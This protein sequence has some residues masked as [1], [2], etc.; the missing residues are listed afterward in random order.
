MEGKSERKAG[1]EFETGINGF[2]VRAGASELLLRLCLFRAQMPGE[3]ESRRLQR[4]WNVYV[5]FPFLFV[6]SSAVY[7]VVGVYLIGLCRG[8]RL[9]VLYVLVSG[10]VVILAGFVFLVSTNDHSRDV[11]VALQAVQN[12]RSDWP[13]LYN[14]VISRDWLC[15]RGWL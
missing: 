14:C 8:D 13:T 15:M 2:V 11:F 10:C 1:C 7:L 12:S 4:L 9:A 3:Y 6:L 5:N